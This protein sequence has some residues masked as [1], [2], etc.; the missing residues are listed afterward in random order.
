MLRDEGEVCLYRVLPD[1]N[2]AFLLDHHEMHARVLMLSHE[3]VGHEVQEHVR[4]KT[5]RLRRAHACA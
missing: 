1:Q 3:G 2:V 5:A 4:E